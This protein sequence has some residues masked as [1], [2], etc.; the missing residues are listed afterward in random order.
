MPENIVA[1]LYVINKSAKRRADGAAASN[2]SCAHT[3][4]KLQKDAKIQAYTIK[5]QAIKAARRMGIASLE[6]VHRHRCTLMA[7]WRV[8]GYTFHQPITAAEGHNIVDLPDDWRSPRVPHTGMS[9]KVAMA[10]LAKLVEET[11]QFDPF[12]FAY[13]GR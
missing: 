5:D 11:S 13:K 8:G 7:C 9:V 12:I 3:M 10:T 1:S 4:A 6:V 2:A